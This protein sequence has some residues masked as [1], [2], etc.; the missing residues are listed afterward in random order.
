MTHR[1]SFLFVILALS[2]L[3]STG[4]ASPEMQQGAAMTIIPV[5][6]AARR[7]PADMFGIY[8]RDAQRP[9]SFCMRSG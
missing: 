8:S 5:H 9:T 7:D 2:L 4:N 3:T 1:I 6:E